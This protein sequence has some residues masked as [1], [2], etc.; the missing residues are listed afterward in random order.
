VFVKLCTLH[1]CLCHQKPSLQ[2]NQTTILYATIAGAAA[3]FFH[4]ASKLR[5]GAA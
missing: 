4:L 3:L 1:F 5:R 2:S